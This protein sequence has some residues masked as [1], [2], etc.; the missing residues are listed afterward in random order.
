MARRQAALSG[1]ETAIWDPRS[2]GSISGT[3]AYMSPEQALGQPPTQASDVFSLGVIIYEMITAR[4]AR[5][6]GNILQM[7]RQ[8]DRE[9]LSQSASHAPEP[10]A[11]IL[12]QALA[13]DP[14]QR[15][16]SMAQIADQLAEHS[17]NVSTG[18]ISAPP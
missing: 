1:D 12:R 15:Q 11:A 9:D 3:P 16:I 17:V 7:L 5:T 13:A 10:I 4:R 18:G 6:E 14:A 8:I 2:S